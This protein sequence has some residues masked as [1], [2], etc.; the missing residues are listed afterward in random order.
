MESEDGLVQMREPLERDV[1]IGAEVRGHR[2]D[3]GAVGHRRVHFLR[4]LPL[5]AVAAGA[6]D[7]HLKMVEHLRRNGKRDV[8]HL[9]PGAYRGRIHIQR[10]PALRTHR[11]RIP[12]LHAGDVLGLEPGT[13]LMSLLPA[14]L[15]SGRLAQGLRMRDAY[16]VPGGRNTAVGAGLGNGFRPA[17]KFRDTGFQLFNLSIFADKAAAQDI[18]N[19]ALLVQLLGQFRGVKFLGKTHIPKE[20][21]TPPG[22]FHPVG[23]KAPAEPCIELSFHTT[24]VGK[25][26]D[27]CKF[28]N[29]SIS[30]LAAICGPYNE[31]GGA[32]FGGPD[33]KFLKVLNRPQRADNRLI[34]NGL[35]TRLAA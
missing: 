10:L 7:L 2:H 35:K 11:R 16:R 13:A 21:L 24:K 22:E 29:L 32:L 5:A 20:L 34:F 17:F 3:V 6:L 4:E 33:V 26:F 30:G 12:A 1:L 9:A 25:R 27:I 23:F 18:I 14:G 31:S 19:K 28:N 15:P 8:H